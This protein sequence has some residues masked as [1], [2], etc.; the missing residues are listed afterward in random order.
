MPRARRQVILDDPSRPVTPD[1]AQTKLVKT[2][3][4]EDGSLDEL[5]AQKIAEETPSPHLQ[6]HQYGQTPCYQ[7]TRRPSQPLPRAEQVSVQAVKRRLNLEIATTETNQT[8]FKAPRGKRR[9]S[10]SS[11]LSGHTPTKSKTVERTRYDTSLSLLTK[12]FINLVESSNDGVVDLNVASEKLEV[13]KRRIYDITNVLEGIGILEKK[14]KNNIQWKGGQL[15]GERNDILDLRREVAD[16]EAKEN[17]LDRLIHGAEK[18]L[19]ELCRDRHYA[20]VTYHDLRSVVAYRDQAIMAVKAP[21]EATLHVPK[22]INNFGQPKLQIHMRSSHGEIE[23]FLCPDD[24]GVRTSHSPSTVTT[25]QTLQHH[26][27]PQSPVV[28]FKTPG[29]ASL[30]PELLINSCV[31]N[32]RTESLSMNPE[33][34]KS[35]HKTP[36]KLELVDSMSMLSSTTGMR[37]ALLCESDDYGPMGGGRFQLQTEDQHSSPDMAMLDFGETLLPLEPPLSESDYPFTLG[38]DEGLS[39]LFDLKF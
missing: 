11:S 21:P 15:P 36:V 20:Y 24:P 14:S 35:E 22:P 38:T 8:T 19:R 29:S 3:F 6:D 7:V 28:T 34:V 1:M 17:T 5:Q 26:Q 23:V 2:E 39:D 27:Q 4:I 30:P 31:S 37:D 10:G 9:R 16:L 13:Q 12:K 25:Q 33:P 18:N 32:S